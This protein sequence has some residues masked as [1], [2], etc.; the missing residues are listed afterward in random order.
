MQ[1]SNSYLVWLLG[2]KNEIPAAAELFTY[3]SNAFNFFVLTDDDA[4]LAETCAVSAQH[5]ASQRERLQRL[6]AI[7]EGAQ[8]GC[9]EM[10]WTSRA[11]EQLAGAGTAPSSPAT[12]STEHDAPAAQD[13]PAR[14]VPEEVTV[15]QVFVDDNF[16]Y[17]DESERYLLGTYAT[18]DEALAAARKLVD[19]FLEYQLEREPSMPTDELV[20]IYVSFGEEP[21]VVCGDCAAPVTFSAW[22][23]AKQRAA[24]LTSAHAGNVDPS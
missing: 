24:E 3:I 5:T 11:R 2:Q 17:M 15:Y 20:K 18:A 19:D 21:F 13:S 16:H 8:P 1:Y 9:V 12:L 7:Y 6:G 14:R 23:Y 10:T 22:D 4:W